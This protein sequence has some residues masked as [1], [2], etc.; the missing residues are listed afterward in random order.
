MQTGSII[1]QIAGQNMTLGLGG[2]RVLVVE[3]EYFIAQDLRAAL[4]AVGAEVI[5]PVADIATALQLLGGQ[6]VRAAVLDINLHGVVDFA[7]AA[8]LT[9]RQIPFVLA[10]GYEAATIPTSY[11]RVPLWRKPFNVEELVVALGNLVT[12]SPTDAPPSL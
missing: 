9:R 5:G 4:E 12:A 8:E 11:E 2:A 7:I 10:T 3:D 1:A 6:T